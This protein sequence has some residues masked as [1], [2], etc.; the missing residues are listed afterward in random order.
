MIAKKYL[1]II[2]AAAL[3]LLSSCAPNLGTTIEA[4]DL[5]TP[6]AKDAIAAQP[7][8]RARLGSYVTIQT[9]TDS[10]SGLA[11][12]IDESY[13]EPYG[14]VSTNVEAA[15]KKA[16]QEAGI[17][18][19]DSAPVIIK[20]EVKKWRAHV[21]T[22]STSM[23]DSE[24]ALTVEVIDPTGKRIYLGNYNGSRSSQFP[25]VTRVDVKDSLAI[26]MQNAITQVISDPQLLELLSAF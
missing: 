2:T 20:A 18:V 1:T 19:T 13:T 4:P 21:N 9:V 10:R 15:L 24:A 23:I 25:V 6:V 8:V 26:A 22:K 7:E 14:G 5:T 11:S 12:N 17:A 16:F 3:T